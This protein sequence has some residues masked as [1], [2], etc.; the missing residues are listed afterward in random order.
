M[1]EGFED[2]DGI[3]WISIDRKRPIGVGSVVETI[4]L[5]AGDSFPSFKTR[6]IANFSTTGED[7][8]IRFY[9]LA[10]EGVRGHAM[11]D[12]KFTHA[13]V[14]RPD[15]QVFR[16]RQSVQILRGFV[17]AIAPRIAYEC[18]SRKKNV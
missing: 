9:G 12:E 7:I 6:H 5:Q 13:V 8:I 17:S 15:G 4:C 14:I 18:V 1:L 10:V 11:T 3:V 16:I 2:A